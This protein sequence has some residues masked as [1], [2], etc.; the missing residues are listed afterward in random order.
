MTI[1]IAKVNTSRI[2]IC[3]RDCLAINLPKKFVD[4]LTEFSTYSKWPKPMFTAI[5]VVKDHNDISHVAIPR[6]YPLDKLMYFFNN[7]IEVKYELDDFI[8]PSRIDI[9]CTSEPRDN[10]QL[11]ALDYLMSINKFKDSEV[12]HKVVELATGIGKTY[13][14]LKHISN[15]SLKPIIFVHKDSLMQTP[16]IK[17][18][19]EHTNIKEDEIGLIAGRPS[20]IKIL[21][22]LD[23]Y[24]V[25]ICSIKTLSS[26]LKTVEYT[27]KFR[28]FLIKAGIGLKIHDETHL[29]YR[30]II[31]ID[32]TYQF[33]Q[34][35]YLSA[36]VDRTSHSARKVFAYMLPD[37]KLRFGTQA[38]YRLPP[39]ISSVFVKFKTKPDDIALYKVEGKKGVSL[40]ELCDYHLIDDNF[41]LIYDN[42]SKL[43]KN[44]P[45]RYR[46]TIIAQK[47]G[48]VKKLIENLSTDFPTKSIG[49]FT[50]MTS[51]NKV[52]ELEKDIIVSTEKSL[53][54]GDDF[55]FH[56]MI[57]LVNMSSEIKLEQ[58]SGRLRFYKNE[59]DYPYLYIEFID[60]GFD[61]LKEQL[62]A[63][64]KVFKRISKK[65]IHIE[66]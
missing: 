51:E 16:W 13:I 7:D 50:S 37:V 35:I 64:L 54:A 55:K 43:I 15:T 32:M 1:F 11:D 26:F 49:N 58:L 59:T 4:S 21:K 6:F 19:L 34:H 52:H 45:S 20:F 12:S 10:T 40:S 57:N 3:R 36:T 14:I 62:K 31:K 27:E 23:K 30:D 63:K 8:E 38:E 29:C 25:F 28:E 47:L 5:Q 56:V 60:I 9:E 24:K 61:K 41:N 42:L 39:H 65:I 33:A 2:L 66:V 17:G 46:I 22:N 48:M 53:D 18:F 44:F